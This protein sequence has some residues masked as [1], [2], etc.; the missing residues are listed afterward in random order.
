MRQGIW[1]LLLILGCPSDDTG[2]AATD[3][4]TSGATA[5]SASGMSSSP[6]SAAST[7]GSGTTEEPEESGSSEASGESGSGESTTTGPIG[8]PQECI[9][10]VDAANAFLAA[11]DAGQTEAAAFDW[12]DEERRRYE[13][14]PPNSAA[15]NGLTLRNVDDAQTMLFETFLQAAMSQPGFMKVS[16]IRAL[17]SVL[18][19]QEEGVPVSDNRDPANYFI[20]FFG[21][22][23]VDGGE[24]WGWRF[25]GHH[26]SI[27]STMLDCTTFS[28]TPAFWG[29]SPTLDPIQDEV[30]LSTQLWAALDPTQQGEAAVSIAANAVDVKVGNVEPFMAEG[31]RAGDMTDDQ[32]NLL[33]DLVGEFAA[34]MNA[35]IE[36]NRL[37]AIEAAGFDEVRFAYDSGSG[38]WRVLGP[39]FLIEFIYSGATHVHAVWRDYDGD[40]GDDLIAKHLHE[41]AH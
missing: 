39:T 14:L 32:V 9:D 24:P 5:M 20:S 4:A 34:N 37:D 19:M 40:Y 10:T 16:E 22:P 38:N 29:A 26:M 25:E 1:G 3:G 6:T 2:G 33:R 27:H 8:P 12:A 23:N 13:Y 35:P 31:L 15:R 30:D 21:T 41:H 17:E 28:A 36:T 11:L 18:A 7:S